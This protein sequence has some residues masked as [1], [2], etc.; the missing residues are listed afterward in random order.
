MHILQGSISCSFEKEEEKK[1][2]QEGKENSPAQQSKSVLNFWDNKK[3]Q[4]Q[5]KWN[6]EISVDE[7]KN[8]HMNVSEMNEKIL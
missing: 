5:V 4:S 3:S 8:M 7:K 1:S 6:D 2:S